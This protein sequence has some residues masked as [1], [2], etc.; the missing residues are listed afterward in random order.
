MN[1]SSPTCW[2]CAMNARFSLFASKFCVAAL[3][4][5][6]GLTACTE[7]QTTT[8]DGG[9][10]TL[11]TQD[12]VQTAQNDTLG[13][14]LTDG[15]GR[16]VYMFK[17]DQR[18]SGESTCYDTCA[19][20]WPPVMAS[21]GQPMAR[22]QAQSGLLD[23]LQRRGGAAQ[24]TYNGWPLYHFAQDQGADQLKGQDVMGFGA[25]WYLLTPKGTEVH[26]GES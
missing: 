18:G 1:H 20:A 21:Q 12:P 7:Q 5:A 22:G 19:Q 17:K 6:L 14:Y 11:A 3:A 8:T 15:D 4:L 13:T 2:R 10:T 23:T 25:E 9:D 24:L 16:A 26:A